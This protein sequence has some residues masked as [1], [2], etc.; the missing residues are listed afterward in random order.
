MSYCAQGNTLRTFLDLYQFCDN[1]GSN[2]LVLYNR[3]WCQ[4][5]GHGLG[6]E[7]RALVYNCLLL[8]SNATCR[9][10]KHTQYM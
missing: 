6:V 5:L 9:N 3:D 8:E 2:L 7:T 4:G 10:L 1:H